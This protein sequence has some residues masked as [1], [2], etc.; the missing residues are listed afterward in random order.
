MQTRQTTAAR[1]HRL[2]SQSFGRVSGIYTFASRVD[3]GRST[4]DYLQQTSVRVSLCSYCVGEAVAGPDQTV[5]LKAPA[6]PRRTDASHE[7]ERQPSR[8]AAGH[9]AIIA[10]PRK[11]MEPRAV[12]SRVVVGRSSSRGWLRRAKKLPVTASK[13][14]LRQ[15][16]QFDQALNTVNVVIL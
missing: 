15:F 5:S 8:S 2:A 9:I 3:Y 4:T 16:R 6:S 1:Y 7:R 13:E 14:L 10:A 11:R 12:K